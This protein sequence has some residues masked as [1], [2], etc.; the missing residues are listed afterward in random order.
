MTI[1]SIILKNVIRKEREWG[2]CTCKRVSAKVKEN[3]LQSWEWLVVFG[4]EDLERRRI[5]DGAKV[6][7]LHHISAIRFSHSWV[8]AAEPLRTANRSTTKWS[9]TAN[10][11]E[12]GFISTFAPFLFLFVFFSF[13][14]VYTYEKERESSKLEGNDNYKLYRW[15]GWFDFY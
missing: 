10:G 5:R 8:V 2:F 13:A 1:G 7:L 14:L 11:I 12:V 6:L 3:N 15:M 4:I 9:L